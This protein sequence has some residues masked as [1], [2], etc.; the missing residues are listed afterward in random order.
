[1][2]F[3]TSMIIADNDPISGISHGLWFSESDLVFEPF[4]GCSSIIH[5]LHIITVF[6]VCTEADCCERDDD[7]S[8]NFCGL[9]LQSDDGKIIIRAVRDNVQSSILH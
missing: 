4:L 9:F 1:M 2:T 3:I 8:V 7:L 5:H 6:L